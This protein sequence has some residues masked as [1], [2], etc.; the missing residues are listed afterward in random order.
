MKVKPQNRLR[1]VSADKKGRL[2]KAVAHYCGTSPKGN[3]T[4]KC[5]KV[6]FLLYV[7]T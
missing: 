7:M 1:K 6:I 5:K 3:N 2:I 4:T